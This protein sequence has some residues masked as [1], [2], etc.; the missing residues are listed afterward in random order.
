MTGAIKGIRLSF[1]AEPESIGAARRAV[2]DYAIGL[3]MT[4]PRLGDLKT[5]VSEASSNVVRHA[6]PSGK[7]SFEI[8]A[9]PKGDSLTVTVRDFG[10][11]L[12]PSMEHTDL[13]CSRLGLGLISVLSNSYEIAGHLDGGT[14]VRF[15]LTL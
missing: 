4:E 8:E 1:D 14:E 2:A 11:G 15:S 9:R 5:S 6:Y 7:G 10:V 13:C 3:G 12:R